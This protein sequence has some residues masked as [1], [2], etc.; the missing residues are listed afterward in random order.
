MMVPMAD[1]GSSE[2]ISVTFVN[3][4][5]ALLAV[6][7]MA[8]T[9]GAARH[10]L[11]S[12]SADQAQ[13]HRAAPAHRT[14]PAGQGAPSYPLD[15]PLYYIHDS[16]KSIALTIDDG[17][18]PVYTPQVLRLLHQYRVTATFSMIGE[19]VAAYPHLA[20]TV[21]EAGHLIANHTWTHA[22][23]QGMSVHQVHGELARGRGPFHDGGCA[24]GRHHASD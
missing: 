20:R 24:V 1:H 15:R 12:G 16:S 3:R 17:P 22:D 6:G 23:L 13:G 11:V 14:A 19:H 18:D 4:R 9:A 10:L 7:G 2:D 8:L 5:R 21:A